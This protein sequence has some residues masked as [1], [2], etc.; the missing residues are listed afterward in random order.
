MM[1]AE[2]LGT[3]LEGFEPSNVGVKVRNIM[4]RNF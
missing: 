3:E 2:F 1:F 4:F